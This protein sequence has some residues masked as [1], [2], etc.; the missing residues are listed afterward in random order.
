[1][2]LTRNTMG[3]LSKKELIEELLK[4]FNINNQLKTLGNTVDNI[5]KNTRF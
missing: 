3:N 5:T 1:M 2:V 4:L